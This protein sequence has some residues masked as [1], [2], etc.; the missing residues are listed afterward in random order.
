MR[1][2][3]DPGLLSD[4]V[5]RLAARIEA[6]WAD[7]GVAGGAG[8]GVTVIGVLGGCVVLLADLIRR[9]KLPIRV[10]HVQ[11]RSYRGHAMRPGELT[12]HAELLPDVEGHDVL[13][14][15]DI[16]DTG[17]TLKALVQS[18]SVAGASSVKTAVL[19]RKLGRQETDLSPDYVAFDIPDVFVVGYGMD[20]NDRY[21][22]LP[23]VAALEA[24]DL[25]AG[26]DAADQTITGALADAPGRRA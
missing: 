6:D 5:D 14:V 15:D 10:G 4:G 22:N 26:G 13:L 3:L 20:Y 21:R 18:L 7:R 8:R 23:Y 1:I 12:I 17:H 19:L 9:L 11:A 2:L 16:F 25:A 24:D